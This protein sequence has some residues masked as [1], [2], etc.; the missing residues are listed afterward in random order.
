MSLGERFHHL[1]VL[2]RICEL[3]VFHDILSVCGV[4]HAVVMS[5]ASQE[6]CF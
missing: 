6:G 1:D 5:A 3:S 4:F 2:V